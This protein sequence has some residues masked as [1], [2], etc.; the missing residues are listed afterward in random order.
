[1]RD[2]EVHFVKIT[3]EPVSEEEMAVLLSEDE[4]L[5]ELFTDR[6]IV[7]YDGYERGRQDFV[8]YFYGADADR[9][10]SVIFPELRHLPFCDRATVLKRNGQFEG[11][12]EMVRLK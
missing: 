10:A 12:E 7:E 9:M 5:N 3:F 11:R 4:R 1:M 2:A 8:M 6:S